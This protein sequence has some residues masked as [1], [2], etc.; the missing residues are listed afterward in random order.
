MQAGDNVV[1]V[2]TTLGDTADPS[3]HVWEGGRIYILLLMIQTLPE[4]VI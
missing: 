3:S 1:Y 4:A 2:S